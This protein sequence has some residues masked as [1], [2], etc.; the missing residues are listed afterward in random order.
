MHTTQSFFFSRASAIV[1]KA[2]LSLQANTWLT[3]VNSQSDLVI[4]ESS[5]GEQ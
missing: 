4:V 3:N 2:K 5:N 1:T